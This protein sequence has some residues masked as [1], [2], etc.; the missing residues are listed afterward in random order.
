[1][2]KIVRKILKGWQLFFRLVVNRPKGLRHFILSTISYLLRIPYSWGL[3]VNVTIEPCNVCNLH[4]PGCE[5]GKNILNRDKGILSIQD[6]KKI[7]DAIS[8]FVNNI[9]LY[10]MGE[11]FVNNNI[12]DMIAYAKKYKIFVTTCTNG[13]FID[14]PRLVESGLDEISFQIGGITQQTH[15]IYRKG[16]DLSEIEKNIRAV[17][18]EKK[19]RNASSPRVLLGYILM[20]HNEHE[21]PFIEKKARELGVDDYVV[22]SP[23]FRTVEEAL[24]DLPT[25]KK[26]W[27]YDEKI[28][29]EEKRLVS[30]FYK[31]NDCSWIWYSTVININGDITPCCRDVYGGYR[32][33]NIFEEPMEKIWNNEKYRAFRR[34]ILTNKREIKMCDVCSGFWIP[35]MK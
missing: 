22:I 10:Y 20:K 5:T 12:Y 4:C 3:P 34:K 19:R 11:P 6:F 23:A 33:G 14:A 2:R 29:K 13:S 26:Y 15:E 35:D 28:L 32:M 31:N 21:L 8:P 17:V 30:K 9:Y 16:S 25:D 7:I 24:E 18:E 27:L 1:M